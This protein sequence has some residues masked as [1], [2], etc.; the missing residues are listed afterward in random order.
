[1]VDAVARPVAEVHHPAVGIGQRRS[2][3]SVAHGVLS[4]E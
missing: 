1:V 3:C 4:L 2:A